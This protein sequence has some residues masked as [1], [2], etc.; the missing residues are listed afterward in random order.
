MELSFQVMNAIDGY[1]TSRIKDHPYVKE[2]DPVTVEILG[3]QPE[4]GETALYFATRGISH[5]LIA[6]AL[7]PKWRPWFQGPT[8]VHSTWYVVNNCELGL[9]PC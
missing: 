1:Q 3:E 8:M 7:P 6:R 5:Y 4:S 9:P 2:V